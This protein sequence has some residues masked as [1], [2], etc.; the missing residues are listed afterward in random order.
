MT[1]RSK[2]HNRGHEKESSW[3]SDFGTG[4]TTPMYIDPDTKE[5]KRGYPPPREVFGIA[6]TVMFDSMPKTYHEGVGREIESRSEWE[7]ADKQTGLLTFGSIEEP[8]RHTAKGVQEERKALARDRRKASETAWQAYKENPK[9]VSQK[10]AKRAEEQHQTA[11]KA[12]LNKL[13]KEAI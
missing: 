7:L 6:P 10:V 1:I 13:I 9:E 4:D 3:P 11:K 2:I 5:V 8:K 12:G